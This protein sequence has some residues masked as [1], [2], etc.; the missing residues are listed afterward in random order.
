MRRIET[1]V[2]QQVYEWA[3]SA[4]A[5]YTMTSIAKV[6]AALFGVIGTVNGLA[7]TPT[8]PATMNVQI[9]AGEIY[10]IEPLE[11]TVCGTLPANTANT[12][13]KQGIQLGTFTT[14]TF[15]TPG[16]SG[17]SINYLIEAQYQD[18]DI[19]LDPTTGTSPVVLQFYNSLNPTT[20]WSGPNNTGSTSNTFRDGVV[21][22]QI[23]AGVAATT[24]SQVT[25][26]PDTGWIGLWVVTVPFGASSLTAGNISQYAAAPIL[27]TGMLQ[28]ILT[29]NLTYGVDNGSANTI[30]ASFPI[31]VTT[32]TDGMDV[33]VKIKAANTSATTFTPNPGVI[34]A[35]PV[36]GA[37]H[38]ALQGGELVANGRAN[39]VW[40]QDITSWV[41]IECTGAAV[42]VA[43]ATANQHA[44]QF[45]QVSGVVGQ[46]RNFSMTVATASATATVTADEVI[47]ETA[48][49]GLRYCL[50]GLN[51]TGNLATQMDTGSAPASGFVAKYVIY[52]PNA[53]ISGTN[54]RL[55]YTNAASAVQPNV[56]GGGFMPA[57]YTASALLS[58]WPTNASSQ[59]VPGVQVDRLFGFAGGLAVNSSATGTLI[60]V[61]TTV[62]PKN[63][64]T[65]S[66]FLQI[67]SSAA[68]A[69]SL[70][71]YP[72]NANVAGQL[73]TC[74]V[75]AGTSQA[76]PFN[77]VPVVTP[78]TFYYTAT[79]GAGTPGFT[80]SINAY[81][82]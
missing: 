55:L 71:I 57:G 39:L 30:Q 19:S 6:C 70:A 75:A 35:S 73:N 2:G 49:G 7:C 65:F 60:S 58:V 43:P 63:A 52:N 17:Q 34:S 48:L 37:A 1:Y 22:Y 12:I 26:S 46:A 41:L 62:I 77:R 38:A 42:Q 40:R 14:G 79:N 76:V 53:A 21:A 59:F 18:S 56:Y 4:Q 29:S 50:T 3:F 66:G 11:A 82:I 23:K 10:Q 68:S 8:S 74:N 13:L 61:S 9:G 27:P 45:G 24:G 31:P 67:G 33:W 54:P 64:K 15:A 78:Q 20:P 36:V 44:V 25:P 28:S 5:Q 69:I 32:L 80:V 81:E 51:L 72:M 16:T 47:V